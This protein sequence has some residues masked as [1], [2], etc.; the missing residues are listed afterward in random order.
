MLERVR[1]FP[2]FRWA[3]LPALLVPALG[4]CGGGEENVQANANAARAPAPQRNGSRPAPAVSNAAANEA[5]NAANAVDRPVPVSLDLAGLRAIAGDDSN[6]PLLAFGS[7]ADLAVEAVSH[8]IGARPAEDAVSTTCGP[9]PTRVIRWNEGFTLLARDGRFAGWAADR[10]GFR[11]GNG[12]AVGSSRNELNQA[13]NVRVTNGADGATFTIAAGG[14]SGGGTLS[15][16]RVTS[17][18][19]GSTCQ[20]APATAQPVRR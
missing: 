13:F 4:G 15:N 18:R 3:L 1:S 9:A 14:R 5:G 20:A 2:R 12:V 10:P 17:L 6:G 11:Y 7:E 19:A 8:V 16:G